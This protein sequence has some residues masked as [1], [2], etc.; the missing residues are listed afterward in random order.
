MP[1]ESERDEVDIEDGADGGAQTANTAGLPLITDVES[2]A[3]MEESSIDPDHP[4]WGMDDCLSAITA[5]T[6]YSSRT[7]KLS[8]MYE[9]LA[10][11]LAWSSIASS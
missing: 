8:A 5:E 2:R 9:E 7:R 4:L 3:S 6:Y 11:S 10:P 1:S